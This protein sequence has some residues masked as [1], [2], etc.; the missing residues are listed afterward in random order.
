ML[1][2]GALTVAGCTD[3]EKAQALSVTQDTHQSSTETVSS[4]DDYQEKVYDMYADIGEGIVY[5]L[6]GTLAL[7]GIVSVGV[8]IS[9][10]RYRRKR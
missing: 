9:D 1:I 10:Y 5:L 6:G 2:A 7:A 3:A 4:S 8:N